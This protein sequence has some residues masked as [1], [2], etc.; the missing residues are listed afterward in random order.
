MADFS[1]ASHLE[2]CDGK[3]YDNDFRGDTR[4]QAGC[5][6]EVPKDR[7]LMQ[8][9]DEG[10][11]AKIQKECSK[12]AAGLADIKVNLLWHLSRAS[13]LEENDIS[14]VS[15]RSLRPSARCRLFTTSPE[16]C[17]A[18]LSRFIAN[19]QFSTTLVA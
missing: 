8:S 11:C 1:Q 6:K 15:D 17:P 7:H 4:S 19:G 3:F 13:H 18:T 2:P 5:K 12:C 9:V 16:A 10:V 14:G